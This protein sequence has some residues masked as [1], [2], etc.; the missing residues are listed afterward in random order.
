SGRTAGMSSPARGSRR[1]APAPR[2]RESRG[3]RPVPRAGLVRGSRADYLRPLA[4]R[5]PGEDRTAP[6]GVSDFKTKARDAFKRKNYELAL[7]IYVEAIQLAPDDAEIWEG[8]VQAAEKGREGKGKSLFG[9]M[10]RMGMMSV[11]DPVK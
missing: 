11:R 10:G 6:M 2:R 3:G 4:R 8:F 1:S 9:G 5:T 7:E